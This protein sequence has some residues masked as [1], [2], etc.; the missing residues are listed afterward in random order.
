MTNHHTQKRRRDD[1]P[2]TRKN[3]TLSPGA[4]ATIQRF[5]DEHNT[6]FSAAVETAALLGIETDTATAIMPMMSSQINRSIKE[7]LRNFIKPMWF[8]ASESGRS[9]IVSEMVLLHVL[10][11]QFEKYHKAFTGEK[12]THDFR[13]Y[14]DVPKSR[15]DRKVRDEASRLAELQTRVNLRTPLADVFDILREMEAEGKR[16][17]EDE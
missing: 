10:Q 6:S 15:I 8:A 2:K 17:I 4:V 14:A 5:A 3:L 13:E 7:A 11:G 12:K 9:R 16:I 1:V